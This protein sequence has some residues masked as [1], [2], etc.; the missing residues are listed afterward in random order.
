VSECEVCASPL[1]PGAFFCGECGSSTRPRL[2][3]TGVQRTDTRVTPIATNPSVFPRPVPPPA[4]SD[5]PSG[6]PVPAPAPAPVPV[7][8]PATPTAHTTEPV[9]QELSFTLQFANGDSISVASGGLLG[10]NPIA[11]TAEVGE[12]LIIVTDPDRT[13]SKTHLEFGIEDGSFWICDRFSGNGTTVQEP[14]RPARRLV[15]GR[16]YRIERG[17]LVGIGEQAF[18]VL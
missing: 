6:V 12:R 15:P 14:G 16:R 17:T 11:A 8:M 1:L 4:F 18:S 10:R 2:D 5:E 13:V 3:P 7:P 9:T